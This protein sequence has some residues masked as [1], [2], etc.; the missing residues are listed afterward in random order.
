MASDRNTM[1][2]GMHVVP[3]HIPQETYNSWSEQIHN[4][5]QTGVQS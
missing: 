1:S 4:R 2:R 5:N 3:S